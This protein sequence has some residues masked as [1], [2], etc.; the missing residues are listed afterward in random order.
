MRCRSRPTGRS[1]GPR[2]GRTGPA[3]PPWT[4][5]EGANGRYG[6][7]TVA[8]VLLRAM[9]ARLQQAR[10]EP[11]PPEPR[12]VHL[13]PPASTVINQLDLSVALDRPTYER[14]LLVC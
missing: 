2:W 9:Q 10:A 1:N 8:Q 3:E 5:V 14:E 13:V 7:M 11:A 6:N 4:I 12:P